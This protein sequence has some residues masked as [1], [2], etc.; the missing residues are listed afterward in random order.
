M[1]KRI[2]KRLVKPHDHVVV[3]PRLP[4]RVKILG[5]IVAVFV[6][7]GLTRLAYLTGLERAGYVRA[8]AAQERSLLKD[9]IRDLEDK[10]STQ[11]ELL[12]QAQRQLQI[13]STAYKELDTA[14]GESTRQIADL[15]E[16]LNF[17]RN[18]IAPQ[19]QRNG[20]QIQS[21]TVEPAGLPAHYHYKLVLI[22]AFNHKD[23]VRGRAEIK[24]VGVEAGQQKSVMIDNASQTPMTINFRYY[25]NL[26]GVVQLAPRFEPARIEVRVLA[27]GT[28]VVMAEKAFPWPQG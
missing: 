17:Y 16:E 4:L 24:V 2:V 23:M 3:R 26:E 13:D 28:N 8:E 14:L 11:K 10:N 20:V 6:V 15:R 1:V 22:Q 12:A 5:A 7:A 25:Q 27:G 18:I 19:D 9:R 21:L